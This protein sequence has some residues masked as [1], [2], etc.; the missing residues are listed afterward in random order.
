MEAVQSMSTFGDVISDVKQAVRETTTEK[1]AFLLS[2]AG[3][4]W[5]D[6][7]RG[8]DWPQSRVT[9]TVINVVSGAQAYDLP[10]DFD[11]PALERVNYAQFLG[12]FFQALTIP[13][14]TRNSTR[15]DTIISLWEGV[16]QPTSYYSVPQAVG[17]QP[18]GANTYQLILYP[19]AGATGDTITL[20]YYSIPP[21]STFTTATVVSPEPLYETLYAALAAEYFRYIR[22]NDQMEIFQGQAKENRMAARMSLARL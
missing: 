11:R 21:R 5:T 19:L 22:D 6:L 1:D 18:G 14:I 3:R 16:I 17:I 20:D 9:G 10:V 8:D 2:A 13:F 4:I 12:T 7:L 15:A